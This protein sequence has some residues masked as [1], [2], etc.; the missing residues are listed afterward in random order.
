VDAANCQSTPLDS[1]ED[2][3]MIRLSLALA[4]LAVVGIGCSKDDAAK[5]TDEAREVGGK[6][7]E[8]AKEVGGTAS[9]KVRAVGDK[10][11]G[12]AREAGEAVRGV[13][14]EMIDQAANAADAGP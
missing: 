9:R 13:G 4:M 12:E 10:A 8:K 14:R 2:A 3:T 7:L 5:A 6:A 11:S 1:G